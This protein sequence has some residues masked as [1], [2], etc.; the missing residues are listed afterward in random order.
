MNRDV[1]SEAQ[2]GGKEEEEKRA[3]VCRPWTKWR[4]HRGQTEIKR[5]T[6]QQ[7]QQQLWSSSYRSSR[8]R[9][10]GCSTR[11]VKLNGALEKR[12][13]VRS[14]TEQFMMI[15]PQNPSVDVSELHKICRSVGFMLRMCAMVGQMA[16]LTSFSALRQTDGRKKGFGISRLHHN[17]R[18]KRRYQD[19]KTT[20]GTS[21][22]VRVLGFLIPRLQRATYTWWRIDCCD[23]W[24]Q[25]KDARS[26]K[27]NKKKK[28]KAG[29]TEETRNGKMTLILFRWGIAMK[30]I[31]NKNK[32]EKNFKQKQ[33]NTITALFRNSKL[34]TYSIATMVRFHVFRNHFSNLEH[35]NVTKRQ[36]QMDYTSRNCQR[37]VEFWIIV[38]NLEIWKCQP[39]FHGK[40]RVK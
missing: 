6:Y 21:S 5:Q 37:L 23:C 28:E 16:L 4:L 39:Q 18:M 30:G 11:K 32:E 25:N 1:T 15:E 12:N 22:S 13:N 33:N 40:V 36:F 17:Y 19:K 3:P 20:T 10:S 31:T 8:A 2:K 7:Q 38:S 14:P 26:R 9:Q 27:N 34:Y 24:R 35:S 29:E